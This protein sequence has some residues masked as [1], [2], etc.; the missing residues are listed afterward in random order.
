MFWQHKFIGVNHFMQNRWNVIFIF[1]FYLYSSSFKITLS[2]SLYIVIDF[3]YPS[4][5]YRKNHLIL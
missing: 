4:I 3:K 1:L 5:F 2:I